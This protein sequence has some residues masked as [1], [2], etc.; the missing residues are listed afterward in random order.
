MS[1]DSLYLDRLAGV[2]AERAIP[3]ET[4]VAIAEAVGTAKVYLA[5]GTFTDSVQLIVPAQADAV[6]RVAPGTAMPERSMLLV[7]ARGSELR[8]GAIIGG[9]T[10]VEQAVADVAPEAYRAAWRELL[11]GMTSGS[12]RNRTRYLTREGGTVTLSCPERT[13]DAEATFVRELG[14]LGAQLG[15]AADWR[16]VYA[17]AGAGADVGVTTECT[18]AG[19]SARI[20]LR[21]GPT[22]W[23][24]AIDLAQAMGN[25]DR[26]R[27][28]AVRM[29]TLAGQ[30]ATDDILGVETVHDQRE[31]DVVVWMKLRER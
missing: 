12:V 15:A 3:A 25:A 17:A 1:S 2:L 19:F 30:F 16:A 21:F 8:G 10:T 14:V 27:D 28:A 5:I 6:A 13:G 9:Q 4:V 31:P 26:A 20:A 24:R 22:R 18:P 7:Y 11:T 23:D 29:G